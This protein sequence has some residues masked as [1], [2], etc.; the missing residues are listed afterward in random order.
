MSSKPVGAVESQCSST[1]DSA[2]PNKCKPTRVRDRIF[3]SARE[4]FSRHGLRGVGVDAIACDAGTNKMSFYRNF[5]SKDELVAECLRES[6]R[7]FWQWWD[8]LTG[9]FEGQPRKQIETLFDA[10][11][12]KVCNDEDRTRGCALAN[13]I[14]EIP[15]VD[16]PGRIVTVEFKARIRARF[17]QWTRELR[18]RDPEVLADS[19]FL[20][21]DGS[22]LSRLAFGDSGPIRHAGHA[23]RALMDQ[24]CAGRDCTG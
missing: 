18:A 20:L 15:D 3:S 14:V 21:M 13:A 4:L 19:L 24:H 22:Y 7:E 5:A 2:E 16:H 11:V 8:E 10:F 23:A 6:E 12:T 1:P 17:V 9:P